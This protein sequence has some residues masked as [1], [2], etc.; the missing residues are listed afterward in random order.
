MDQGRPG[1]PWK[2]EPTITDA[3]QIH[4]GKLMNGRTETG[5]Q[6]RS[7]YYGQQGGLLNHLSLAGVVGGAVLLAYGYLVGGGPSIGPGTGERVEALAPFIGSWLVVLVVWLWRGLGYW[8]RA[9]ALLL[10]GYL[11]AGVLLF[12]Q[13]LSGSGRLWLAILPGFA[14]ALMGL[15]WGQLAA[16]FSALIYAALTVLISRGWSPPRS[17]SPA[18]L[19]HWIGESG[20]FLLLMV[21]LILVLRSF[22]RGW[23]RALGEADVAQKQ[24]EAGRE[25]LTMVSRELRR[26]SSQLQTTTAIA[27]VGASSL[28]LDTVLQEVVDTI[29]RGFGT[30]GVC[31]VGCFLLEESGDA[32]VL[33]AGASKVGRAPLERGDRLGLD[34]QSAVASAV[35]DQETQILARSVE[36]ADQVRSEIALPLRSADRVI[37]AVSLLSARDVQELAAS[38]GDVSQLQGV[39]DQVA[40]TVQ[41]AR[42]FQRAQTAL[43]ELEALRRRYS[44]EEWARFL[45]K[46]PDFQV[47]YAAPGAEPSGD[48]FLGEARKLAM[49]ANRPVA[50]DNASVDSDGKSDRDE[51]AL[52]VPLRLRGQ[53]VGTIAL[54]ETRGKPRWTAEDVALTETVAQEVAQ[55]V[56]GLLLMA[57]SRRRLA[58][59]RLVGDV[60]AQMRESLDVES[61]LRTG[62]EGIREAMGLPAVTVRLTDRG[63]K[64]PTE[65]S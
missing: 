49:E 21:A 47:D 58:R 22:D 23:V 20:G 24:L 12:R 52:V 63:M 9:S 6:E 36:S 18:L 26:K 61:V 29:L 54:H 48:G 43:G 16:V 10:S 60:V 53:P 1:H 7:R 28:D 32:L 14:F 31:H 2:I 38:E 41:N 55:T 8:R 11:V 64:E 40:L 44:T 19:E 25:K 50:R 3:P 13:G 37:G 34:R 39:A 57:E 27:Q 4:K 62:A 5:W 33:R 35:V 51:G 15:R 30:I 17:L 46:R 65:S 42:L 45:A 56:E 59:E